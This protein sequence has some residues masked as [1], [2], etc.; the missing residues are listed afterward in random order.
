[1]AWEV[2]WEKSGAWL[3]CHG[4]L[5]EEELVAGIDAIQQDPRFDAL[6]YNIND[7]SE[8]R[9]LADL[10]GYIEDATVRAIGG[11]YS[12]PRILMAVVLPDPVFVERSRA[13][14]PPGFPYRVGIFVDMSSA[15]EWIRGSNV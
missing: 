7:F 6:R 9:N 11:A 5:T 14:F 15:R 3:R 13:N 2:V 12:N 4:A 1:V 8:V 10:P